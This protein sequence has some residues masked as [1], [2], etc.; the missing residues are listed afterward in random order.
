[1]I[2]LGAAFLILYFLFL[3]SFFFIH[4][5]SI[6]HN[7]HPADNY[8]FIPSVNLICSVAFLWPILFLDLLALSYVEFIVC[9][10]FFSFYLF[11]CCCCRDIHFTDWFDNVR[12]RMTHIYTINLRYFWQINH[13]VQSIL[14]FIIEC[15]ELLG[16]KN[17]FT[18][19]SNGIFCSWCRVLASSRDQLS[20]N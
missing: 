3:A 12:S 9:F 1:M 19:R 18:F 13:W 11:F 2:E 5:Y 16:E 6:L 14:L 17:M 10:F 8:C 20:I 7:S 15:E 4:S